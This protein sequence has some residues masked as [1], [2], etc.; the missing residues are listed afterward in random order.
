MS[1]PA[2][3]LGLAPAPVPGRW[4]FWA[5]AIVGAV[6]L[7]PVD[8]AA[9]SCTSLLSGFGS[10]QVTIDLPSGVD[11]SRLLRLW[12]WRL[13]AYYD[14]A[15]YWCG[16]PSGI[17]DDG[18]AQ[19]GLTLTELPGYLHKRQMDVFP[20]KVYTGVEQTTIAAEL[21]A[22]L[23]AVGVAV[24]AQPG[25]GFT[26][27]RTY[28]YL[29][30]NSRADLLVNLTQVLSG[31]E[32]RA[33]YSTGSGGLPGCTLR[34]AYP[35]VGSGQGGLGV[36]VDGSALAYSGAWDADQLRTHTFA[37]GDLPDNAAAGTPAPVAVVDNPQSD[38]P[39]LDAV[40]DWP[41]VVLTTTLKERA[42]AASQQQAAPA[43]KLSVT[44]SEAYPALGLYAV[45]DDVT[46]RITDPLIPDGMTATGRLTQLDVDAAAGTAAW[47][48]AVPMPPPKTRETLTGRLNRLDAKVGGIFRGGPLNIVP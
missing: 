18:R 14:G 7:G 2:G 35:R 25:A 11:S 15:P 3:L 21:A 43:L 47:T 26:R 38:L 41:G 31:P 33:E 30:G 48:V 40:D 4:T 17:T 27:D 23:S 46:V 1:D 22:P 5:D 9:F 12:S 19:V 6:P 24:V 34:I 16:V 10:G 45:G 28:E 8:V 36:T 37:V 44:P 42:D 20:S 29:G 39:R 32:F 13:W